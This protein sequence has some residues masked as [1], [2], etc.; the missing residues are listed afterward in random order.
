M[1]EDRKVKVWNRSNGIHHFVF[2]D[3]NRITPIAPGGFQRIPIEEVYYVNVSS[4]SF[5]K[6][7]LEIDPSE[8]ELLEELGYIERNP[9]AYTKEEFRK[10]LSGNLTKQVK[11]KLSQISEYH[12][13]ANLIEVAREMDLT[14]SKNKFIEKVTGMKIDDELLN[15]GKDKDEDDK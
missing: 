12:S 2:T 13:K 7:I 3:P 10:I 4:N 9:N 6:G 8:I 14:Q 1:S 11:D 15:D 5:R